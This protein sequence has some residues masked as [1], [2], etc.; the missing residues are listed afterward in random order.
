MDMMKKI[1]VCLLALA[2]CGYAADERKKARFDCEAWA[3]GDVPKEVFVVDGTIKIASKDG[4]KAIMIAPEP[5]TDATAQIGESSR[6]ASS[7]Q[8][9]VFATKRGRSTPRVG[10][11]VHGLSGHRLML[12]LAKKQLELSFANEVVATAPYVWTSDAWTKMSLVVSK[13]SETEWVIEG[14]AWQA[15]GEEPKE[16]QLKSTAADLKAQGK[17]AI[18]G[19]PFSETPIYFDDIA[20]ATTPAP[21]SES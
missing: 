16:P 10:V 7:I 13:K 6:G 18:W 20:V 3:E 4:G 2:A 1:T 9:R 12:N 11:S 19:S 5:I 17:C 21:K 8:A 15:D 14:K